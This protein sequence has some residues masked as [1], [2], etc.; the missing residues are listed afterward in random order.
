MRQLALMLCAAVCGCANP[1]FPRGAPLDRL[2]PRVDSTVP[3]DGAV[4]ATPDEVDFVFPEVV[5]ERPQGAP[6]LAG[7]FLISPSSGA[8]RVVWRR[9][10]LSVRPRNGWLPNTTYTITMLPGVVDLQN[11]V[12][13]EGA[14]L[15]FSTGPRIDSAKISGILF[16]WVAERPFPRAVVRARRLLADS[17]AARGPAP[18]DTA[19][20]SAVTD[21]TGRFTLSNLPNGVYEI[22]GFIDGNANRALDSLESYDSTRVTLNDSARVELLA[23]VHDVNPPHM[24]PPAVRDSFTFSV[25]FS[26]PI[27]PAQVLDTTLFHLISLPDSAPVE[28]VLVRPERV[29]ERVMSRADSARQDS[30]QRADSLRRAQNPGLPA[31]VVIEAVMPS[32]PKPPLTLLFQ[33]ATP[34]SPGR[35]YILRA[36]PVRG[37]LGTSLPHQTSFTIPPPIGRG[38]SRT[39]RE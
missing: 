17:A 5:S 9:Q 38:G 15:V 16:D 32:R 22:R 26:R 35:T 37:L 11:N 27:D 7:M 28:I 18:R 1:S 30:T 12:S 4:N 8:P 19:V 6:D 29:T 34:L 33:V 31:T 14:K 39:Q 23:F 10:R 20:Y 36:G 25:Q 24:L 3:E 2:A 21:S 13:K